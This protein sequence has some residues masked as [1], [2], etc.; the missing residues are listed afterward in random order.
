MGRPYDPPEKRI[1][2]FWSMVQKT[3]GCWEWTGYVNPQTGY[4]YT[5]GLDRKPV[6]VHR[7][8][9][10][11]SV[12]PIPNGLLVCHRCDNKICVRPDHLFLGTVRDNAIDAQQKGRLSHGASHHTSKLTSEQVKEIVALRALGLSYGALGRQFSICKSSVFSICHGK[13]RKHG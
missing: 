5:Y 4:A 3:D 8:A 12:G 1:A 13:H 11:I 10:R 6:S 9:Y 2:R 7:E